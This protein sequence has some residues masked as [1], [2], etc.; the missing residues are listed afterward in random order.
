MAVVVSQGQN[1]IGDLRR[2]G[3]DIRPHRQRMVRED[4]DTK[5]K[6]PTDPFRIVFVCA[7]WSTGFDVPSCS[8]IYLDKPQRNHTLMQTI[9]RANRVHGDKV[10]GLIV[11]YI[12][13]FRDLERAL[14]IYA[15]G[16]DEEGRAPI[17]DKSRLVE[18]L[19]D[20]IDEAKVFCAS[21]GVDLAQIDAASQLERIDLIDDA[22]DSILINDP[23]KRE[24]LQHANTVL[25]LYKAILPDPDASEFAGIHSLI[26]IITRKINSVNASA[27]ISDVM[28]EIENILD[29][30]IAPTSYLI[31][32]PRYYETDSP[33]DLSQ[34]DFDELRE[35]F[36]GRHQQIEI[37][38]LRGAINR[39][40]SQLIHLNRTRMNYQARFEQM[41][42]EYNAASAADRPPFY[43]QFIAFVGELNAEE[44]RPIAEHLSEEELALFDQLIQTELELT[45]EDREEVKNTVR[46]LLDSLRETLVL[47][48]SK[49]QQSRAVVLQTI[50]EVLDNQLPQCYT[51]ELYDQMCQVVYQHI[52][53]SYFGEGR[54]IYQIPGRPVSQN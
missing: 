7:M 27:D 47:D 8:T 35:R 51:Q 14:T 19:R 40:L 54:S 53:D 48:W 15:T 34:I 3:V 41:I 6:D 12:G 46:Q 33:I 13:V 32:A 9:A 44:H 20:A 25:K 17:Q 21:I 39:K 42:A 31:E 2:T 49:R 29:Q 37:E 5:F 28:T 18:Q 26:Y 11:D 4:L 24:Y 10:N 45:E 1:E 50:K 43:E 22:T 52:R 16:V 23:T 30:S 38:R 36:R